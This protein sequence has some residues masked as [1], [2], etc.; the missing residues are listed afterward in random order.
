MKTNPFTAGAAQIIANVDRFKK[1]SRN[2]GLI[3][4]E[5]NYRSTQNLLDAASQVIN[6]NQNRTPKHLFTI[7]EMENKTGSVQCR[8]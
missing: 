3:L 1:I 5:Q 4:L 7:G 2:A 8:G 6:R